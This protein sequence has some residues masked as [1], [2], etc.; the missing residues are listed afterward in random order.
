MRKDW[1][2]FI[3]VRSGGVFKMGWRMWQASAV[4]TLKAVFMALVV[5]PAVLFWTTVATTQTNFKADWLLRFQD[6]VWRDLVWALVLLMVIVS[7]LSVFF[8]AIRG[9]FRAIQERALE[10]EKLRWAADLIESCSLLDEKKDQESKAQL[11][12]RRASRQLDSTEKE[13]Y[14]E[15]FLSESEL[16][17]SDSKGGDLEGG[18]LSQNDILKHED[19]VLDQSKNWESDAQGRIEPFLSEL[20]SGSLK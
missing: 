12:Q 10:R 16:E 2:R 3:F 20:S 7:L 4:V 14:K 13:G 19:A 5:V 11:Q 9:D 18:D 8:M 15:K 1:D 6:S 17:G